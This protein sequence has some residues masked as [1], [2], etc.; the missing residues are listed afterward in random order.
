MDS[1]AKRLRNSMPDF[2]DDDMAAVLAKELEEYRGSSLADLVGGP[3]VQ[4][5]ACRYLEQ[6]LQPPCIYLTN[7]LNSLLRRVTEPL[8]TKITAN[9][10][11]LRQE[12][13]SMTTDIS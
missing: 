8:V 10:P 4:S 6:T 9:Y 7:Q 2:W 3:A 1:S 12:L 13:I 5:T 11:L